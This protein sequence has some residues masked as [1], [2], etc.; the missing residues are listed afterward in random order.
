MTV[1][2]LAGTV[3]LRLDFAVSLL[4]E[5]LAERSAEF[6]IAL[7][8][9]TF[10][11][12]EVD[13]VPS[14]F[15][16]VTLRTVLSNALFEPVLAGTVKTFVRFGFLGDS[17][18][19]DAITFPFDGELLV[20]VFLLLADATCGTIDGDDDGDEETFLDVFSAALPLG[21]CGRD[22]VFTGDL[23]TAED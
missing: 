8:R 1:F 3:T 6:V 2:P 11:A 22:N 13:E 20:T 19:P 23:L 17:W 15:V 18:E 16:T 7:L 9:T 14:F 21:D 10:L 4:G 12:G 5:D